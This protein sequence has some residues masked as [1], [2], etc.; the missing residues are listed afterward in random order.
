LRKKIDPY[1]L[2]K[3][4]IGLEIEAFATWKLMAK[5]A[6]KETMRKERRNCQGLISVLKAKPVR[7]SSFT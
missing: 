3:A 1:S 7:E 2:F 6:T 4:F 5:A